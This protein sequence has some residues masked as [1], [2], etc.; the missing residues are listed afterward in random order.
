MISQR[1][2]RFLVFYP[3]SGELWDGVHGTWIATSGTNCPNKFAKVIQSTIDVVR[4][5]WQEGTLK[6]SVIGPPPGII[7]G[8]CCRTST[9]TIAAIG[10]LCLASTT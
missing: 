6:G 1:Y 8:G 10:A 5:E 9:D 2:H 3:N 4:Q 7:V